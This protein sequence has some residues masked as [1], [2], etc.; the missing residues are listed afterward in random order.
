MAERKG[1]E[2]FKQVFKTYFKP[3][4]PSNLNGGESRNRTYIFYFPSKYFATKLF[5]LN[6]HK[7]VIYK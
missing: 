6:Q 4:N 1:I 7:T 3:L 5:L 2:P